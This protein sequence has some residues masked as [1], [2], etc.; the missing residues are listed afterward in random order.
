M[1]RQRGLP[2]HG[3]SLPRDVQLHTL[4]FLKVKELAQLFTISRSWRLLAIDTLHR[5]THIELFG[6][7]PAAEINF[8]LQY[9]RRLKSINL[10]FA[11][12]VA[13]GRMRRGGR[14]RGTPL[15]N[16]IT[17][18]A[19]TLEVARGIPIATIE[20]PYLPS[21]HTFDDLSAHF[22]PDDTKRLI[23]T[24]PNLTDIT[25]NSA[26]MQPFLNSNLVL[27]R[28]S[29]TM[30]DT[31]I[32]VPSLLRHPSLE[33]LT[34]TICTDHLPQ[35]CETLTQLPH[36]RHLWLDLCQEARNERQRQQLYDGPPPELQPF[37]LKSL[38]SLELQHL[39]NIKLFDGIEFQ[40]RLLSSLLAPNLTRLKV[41]EEQDSLGRLAAR[42]PTLTSL[43]IPLALATGEHEHEH[44]HLESLDIFGLPSL[45]FL[46]Q[47]YRMPSLKHL[48]VSAALATRHSLNS[49][50]SK[51][52][53]LETLTLD[54][55]RSSPSPA[56]P[57]LE[58]VNLRSFTV[59][60]N[61]S[62]DLTADIRLPKLKQRTSLHRS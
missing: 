31:M 4:S 10:A 22:S 42:F 1:K 3:M 18:N 39:I 6:W 37:I 20:T 16:L 2:P 47:S 21:L 45:D 17:Q 8:A 56:A 26:C 32:T 38:T 25:L 62:P 53:H 27:R 58:H 19:S 59:T 41:D 11:D 61:A 12:Y 48:Y 13:P 7:T 15:S 30:T 36:L 44:E 46:L 43:S 5:L 29:Y 14:G 60:G 50:L 40:K 51:W 57:P 23:A 52:P 9:C 34:L 49:L 28:L 54:I 33:E 55:D 24:C 35:L